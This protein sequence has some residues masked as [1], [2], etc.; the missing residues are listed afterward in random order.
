MVT[1]S[2]IWSFTV[3]PPPLGGGE[4]VTDEA[5]IDVGKFGAQAGNAQIQ[6][7]PIVGVS[8][9]ANRTHGG[10]VVGLLCIVIPGIAA[11]QAEQEQQKRYDF[12]HPMTSP[13]ISIAP[14]PQN[15]RGDREF[16]AAPPI[17]LTLLIF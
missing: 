1:S 9:V 8:D 13:A 3:D 2:P 4:A 14:L 7:L 12:L 16:A 10:D 11:R 6:F 17:P 15:F 5:E